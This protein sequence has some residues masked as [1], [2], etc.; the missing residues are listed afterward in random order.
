MGVDHPG[1]RLGKE[2]RHPTDFGQKHLAVHTVHLV[3]LHERNDDNGDNYGQ[4]LQ[5]R[6]LA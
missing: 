3:V 4:L 2:H 1:K 5:E 6:S